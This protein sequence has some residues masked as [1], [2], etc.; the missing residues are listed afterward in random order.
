MRPELII[1]AQTTEI[2]R[3]SSMRL[4]DDGE[5]DGNGGEGG[6]GGVEDDEEGNEEG[7]EED[8]GGGG[9]GGSGKGGA[10]FVGGVLVGGGGTK[11]PLWAGVV[12][13]V[14]AL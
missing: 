8:E 13:R 2:E 1:H 11:R 12:P 7:N 6:I 4:W 10:G 5:P 14:S 3:P 9:G